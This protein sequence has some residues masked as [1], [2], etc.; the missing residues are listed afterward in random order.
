MADERRGTFLL[1]PRF[2]LFCIYVMAYMTAR[3]YGEVVYQTM[4]LRRGNQVV[5]EHM[6]GSN[7]AMPRWRRQAYRAVFSPLMVVEE[8][9]RRIMSRGSGLLRDA[10]EYGRDYLPD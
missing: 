4:D 10:R 1:R 2:L 7:P 3:A 9:G 8:E 5:Q 6:V